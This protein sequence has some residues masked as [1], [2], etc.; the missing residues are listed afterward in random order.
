MLRGSRLLVTVAVLCLITGSSVGLACETCM[1]WPTG[2]LCD[3]SSM[4]TSCC[5]L[6]DGACFQSAD[7]CN[8]VWPP[9]PPIDVIIAKMYVFSVE[10]GNYSSF[11][12]NVTA[13]TGAQIQSEIATRASVTGTSVSLRNS[14][15]SVQG[16][17]PC[18]DK[19]ARGLMLRTNGFIGRSDGAGQGQM[20]RR[21]CGF[22][23]GQPASVLVDTTVN[24]QGTT[25]VHLSPN[26]L[27]VVIAFVDSV[28]DSNTWST[29]SVSI[30]E[31]FRND[32]ASLISPPR[33]QFYQASATTD[34]Q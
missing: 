25:L 7:Q 6:V 13:A 21:V 17:A 19:V 10:G 14:G 26:G 8:I 2:Y 9:T 16:Q 27:D 30:Q 5:D 1:L 34:C 12:A 20:R 11:P 33:L 31:G 15:F 22:T 29:S 3:K 23:P 28:L 18:T 32:V 24:Q 4:G